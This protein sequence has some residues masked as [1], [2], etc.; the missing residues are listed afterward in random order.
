MAVVICVGV[1]PQVPEHLTQGFIVL[2]RSKRPTD[3]VKCTRCYGR[4]K[5]V[6]LVKEG[7]KKGLRG[8]KGGEEEGIKRNEGKALSIM[9]LPGGIVNLIDW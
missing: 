4:P 6:R 7:S 2:T 8:E 5:E 3:V 1:V 9:Y